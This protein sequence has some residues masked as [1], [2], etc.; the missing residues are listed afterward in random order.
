MTG[1]SVDNNLTRAGLLKA[2]A[3]AAIGAG[4]GSQGAALAGA[5]AA[6]SPVRRAFAGPA[7]LTPEPYRPLVGHA[8]HAQ[9]NGMKPVELRLVEVRVLP[10]PG[11]TFSLL[12]RGGRNSTLE[13]ATHRLGNASLGTFELFLN[14]VDRPSGELTVEALVNRI[15][16]KGGSH[17]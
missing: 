4:V 13:S 7:Y 6:P 9:R 2:G 15:A 17:G 12:F 14:P 11:D 1:S 5:A 8:F 16:S 10:G 3:V